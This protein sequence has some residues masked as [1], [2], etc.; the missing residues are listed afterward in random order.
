LPSVRARRPDAALGPPQYRAEV[1][2]LALAKQA[3]H[4]VVHTD[5][6]DADEVER[7]VLAWLRRIDPDLAGGL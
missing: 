7:R 3:A 5:G 4:V 2:R 1:A 6:I